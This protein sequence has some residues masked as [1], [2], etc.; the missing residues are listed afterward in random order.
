MTPRLSCG[1]R[2]DADEVNASATPMTLKAAGP[3][4]GDEPRLQADED[5]QA[6]DEHEQAGDGL[7]TKARLPSLA[8]PPQRAHVD[9]KRVSPWTLHTGGHGQ[10][11]CAASQ[12]DVIPSDGDR[13]THGSMDLP[14]SECAGTTPVR[15]LTDDFSANSGQQVL[16]RRLSCVVQGGGLDTPLVVRSAR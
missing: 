10:T 3:S 1:P 4:E 5:E 2:G 11:H 6:G 12:S 16:Q 8:P 14:K 13:Q 9:T 15:H 7:S